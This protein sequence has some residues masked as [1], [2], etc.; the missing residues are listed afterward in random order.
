MNLLI[1]TLTIFSFML[2]AFFG[3]PMAGLFIM[4]AFFPAN[5]GPVSTPT[6]INVSMNIDQAPLGFPIHVRKIKNKGNIIWVDAIEVAT[7]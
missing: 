7:V 5:I 1:G 6:G 3:L 2:L 4:S